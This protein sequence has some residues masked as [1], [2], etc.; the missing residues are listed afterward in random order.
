MYVIS[1]VFFVT[2]IDLENIALGSI[3]EKNSTSFNFNYNN[4]THYK[5]SSIGIEINYPWNWEIEN[6]VIIDF[7]NITLI[8]PSMGILL[9]NKDSKI[10]HTTSATNLL[11][12]LPLFVQLNKYNSTNNLNNI[13]FSYLSIFSSLEGSTDNFAENIRIMP[14]IISSDITLGELVNTIFYMIDTNCIYYYPSIKLQNIIDSSPVIYLNQQ[15]LKYYVM[16][17][18]DLFDACI[19]SFEVVDEGPEIIGN[20]PSYQILFTYNLDT[21]LETTSYKILQ[22]YVLKNNQ[23]Y[24]VTYNA[25]ENTFNKSLPVVQIM[26]KSLRIH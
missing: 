2:N 15:S 11:D 1:L 14:N 25:L 6:D 21:K 19:D 13:T 18:V 8:N 7:N 10:R 5:N 23:L 17:F 9:E 20:N 24:I 4:F 3:N 26:L 22:N 16:A 12:T